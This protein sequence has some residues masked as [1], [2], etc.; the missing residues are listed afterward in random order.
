MIL[1][2]RW[3]ILAGHLSEPGFVGFVDYRDDF[4]LTLEHPGKPLIPQIPVQTD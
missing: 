2:L 3:S 1:H 4:A